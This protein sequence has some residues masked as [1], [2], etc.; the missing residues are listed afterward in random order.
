MSEGT[1]PENPKRRPAAFH[2]PDDAP[3]REA[4]PPRAETRRPGRFDAGVSMIEDK[5]DPFLSDIAALET[6]A[7]AAPARRRRGLSL[8]GVAA[9]AFGILASLALGLWTDRLIRDL[10]T[11]ADWLGYTA[12][13]ATAIGLAA[14]LAI[15]MRELLGL[16][17]LAAVQSLKEEAEAA[18]LDRSPKRAR[19]V[20]ARLVALT[21][22][23]PETALA[24]ER[25]NA[26]EEDIIDSRQMI[27]L[28]ERELLEPLDRRARQLIL[29]AARRVS[30]VTAVSPR[31][32]VDLSYVLY[33]AARL[34]RAMA[35]LYGGRPG[36]FGM[37]RLMRD[38][39]AH[40]AVTG[41]I[42]VGDGIIQQVI[43][44]GLASKLSAR[45]GEGVVNGLMTARIGIAAMDYCRPLPFRAVR[46]PGI[47][48]FAGDLRRTDSRS[49]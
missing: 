2:L 27:E 18:M 10:F 11:R 4:T 5:D 20:T 16:R 31:A 12:L 22:G 15:L 13:A 41:S 38:V 3:S 33:E 26:T 30:I 39:L 24:R 35:E 49:E 37:L 29:G 1:A 40:L 17:R 8:A 21:A 34:V 44:H 36:T 32:I 9:S 28:A 43:G 25:L 7:L 23:R 19:A 6:D 14:L 45:L 46:R 48:D 42:A 47:G